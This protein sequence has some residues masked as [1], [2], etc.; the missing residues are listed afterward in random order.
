M[1]AVL[2]TETDFFV[3]FRM[4]GSNDEEPADC[5]WGDFVDGGAN[6]VVNFFS[7][8]FAKN[9]AKFFFFKEIF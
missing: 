6:N 9:G 2:H 3:F 1:A 5:A 4:V 8:F 7:G